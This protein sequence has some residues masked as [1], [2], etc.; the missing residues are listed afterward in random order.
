MVTSRFGEVSVQNLGLLEALAQV[1]RGTARHL[2]QWRH[3]E[4]RD[5]SGIETQESRIGVF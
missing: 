5:I 2:R 1:P 3:K 4:A